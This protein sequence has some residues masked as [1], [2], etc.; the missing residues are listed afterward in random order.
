MSYQKLPYKQNLTLFT[1]LYQLTMG[2][3]YWAEGMA[4]WESVFHHFY[5][6]NPSGGGHTVAAGLE[7]LIDYLTNLRF[8]EDDIKYLTSVPGND[9]KPLFR[10]E[11]LQY[12]KNLEFSCDV[13]AVPEGTVMFPHEPLV[14]VKGHLLMAQFVETALLNLIN[15]PTAIATHA[16]RIAWAAGEMPVLDFSA[17][18]A[19]GIDGAFTAT[20]SAYIGGFAG[21]SNV[22]AARHLGIPAKDIK[23]TMAHSLVMSFDTELEAFTAYARAMPNNCLFL[24]DTYGT[25]EG[26]RH[27]I[28]VGKQLRANGFE[29][30][31]IR[32]DSGDLA[33]LSRRARRM[34]DEA[35]FRKAS[36]VATNDL[37]EFL[38]QSL[39]NQD[40]MITVWGVGTNLMTPSLAG[41]YKLAAIRK[42]GG[43][44]TPKIKLS[45]QPIKVS[46]PGTLQ[47]RRY[48][49][50]NGNIADCI[51]DEHTDIS[52][53]GTMISMKD[54]TKQ[55]RLPPNAQSHNLLVPVM[56]GG[57]PVYQLPTIEQIR[58][59]RMV[60][61][62]HVSD[63]TKRF[64]NPD[65]Y[66]VG[67]EKSLYL[68]RENLIIERRGVSDWEHEA[69]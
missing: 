43:D 20:R 32:L 60:E 40:A 21:T 25:I 37:N 42:P 54:Q 61:L 23:G 4:E 38:I 10:I 46:I 59:H 22:W 31:G 33:R 5:R 56:R 58:H 6:A 39:R 64:D 11:Y 15:Y 7:F 29:M 19:P 62:H 65:E 12:L 9:G 13:D 68:Q 17:R 51:Y 35:D 53:G 52:Q 45:D 14:R 8:E 36:I 24:V 63:S 1:D 44:W 26:V 48:R 18:R 34:L 3:V 55:M 16:A 2:Q 50:L 69:L 66:R 30:L 27:A 28:E 47:V 49:T 67:L 57:Q 41:V